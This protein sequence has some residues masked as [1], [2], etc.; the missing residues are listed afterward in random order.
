MKILKG[1]IITP[2]KKF[3]GHIVV[4]KATIMDVVKG[5]VLESGD[6]L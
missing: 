1:T 5:E 4:E 6:T 2:F 3:F